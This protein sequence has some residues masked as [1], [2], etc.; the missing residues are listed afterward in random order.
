M[1]PF[2]FDPFTGPEATRTRNLMNR[3]DMDG[4][5]AV[6]AT[7]F[8]DN[9]QVDEDSLRRYV[10]RSLAQGVVGFLAP[11]V[12]G[13]VGTLT[14][15][16]RNLVVRTIID[17]VAGQVPVIGGAT[18]P[19][20][21]VRERV[22]RHYL[23]LGCEGILAHLPFEDEA[24]YSLAVGALARLEPGFLMIQDLDTGPV[25]VSLLARLYREV[26][27]FKWAKIET[28]DRCAKCSTLLQETKGS[29][30]V[31]SS[32]PDMIELLDRGVHAYLPT[33]YHD[34]YGRIWSLHRSGRRDDAVR[35]WQQLLP[36]LSFV[37]TH[38]KIHWRVSK[39]VLKAEGIFETTRLRVEAP[40]PDAFES[41]LIEELAEYAK[42][43]S[44][45]IAR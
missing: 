43:L 37:A 5:I 33:L 19:D 45:S 20:P 13:E 10:R 7:P 8:T 14:L 44:N 26:P 32:G 42:A 39:A 25:P 27:A 6:P 17:E 40:E 4:I 11:A 23:D 15:D 31:G 18:D 29:L 2:R 21:I 24:S 22:A 9:N 1:H 41:R 38:H 34:I 30:R 35:L 3:R 28:A 36:C 12:A 16:E